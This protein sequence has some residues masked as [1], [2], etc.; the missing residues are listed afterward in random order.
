MFVATL[1]TGGL[2]G[3]QAQEKFVVLDL[4][5]T[6]TKLTLRTGEHPQLEIADIIVSQNGS[7]TWANTASVSK[8]SVVGK[9]KYLDERSFSA[10]D[11]DLGGN[12][13]EVKIALDSAKK[14][15]SSYFQ[16][17]EVKAVSLNVAGVVI[18]QQYK[19]KGQNRSVRMLTFSTKS[20][21]SS[22]VTDLYE[23]VTAL[24]MNLSVEKS[25]EWKK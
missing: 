23:E 2:A 15:Y 16:D 18:L 17:W 3:A 6:A 11:F 5:G 4:P 24:K 14:L 12:D 21:E 7:K 13:P 20:R 19:G 25:Y 8:L 22:E 10:E 9:S 1:I